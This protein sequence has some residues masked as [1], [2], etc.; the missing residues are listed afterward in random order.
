M[1]TV[2]EKN[3]DE[4]SRCFLCERNIVDGQW[5]ARVK[6]GGRRVLFCQPQCVESFLK[7]SSEHHQNEGNGW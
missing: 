1:K 5:F 6:V 4:S 3:G 2:E 7:N